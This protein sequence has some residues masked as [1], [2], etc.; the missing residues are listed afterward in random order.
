MP[1]PRRWV[2]EDY[3]GALP[4]FNMLPG[5][6]RIGLGYDAQGSEMPSP[7]KSGNSF[8]SFERNVFPE[9]LRL[10]LPVTTMSH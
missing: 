8:E 1:I 7:V 5:Y 9:A 6:I 2:R 4:V 3:R 10:S